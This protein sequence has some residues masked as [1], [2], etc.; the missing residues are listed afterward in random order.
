MLLL[1]FEPRPYVL[2]AERQAARLKPEHKPL[3][4][5]IVSMSSRDSILWNRLITAEIEAMTSATPNEIAAHRTKRDFDAM[6]KQIDRIE[7]VPRR[8]GEPYTAASRDEI[9]DVLYRLE[10]LSQKEIW[11]AI[12]IRSVLSL[13]EP[14][15]SR[16]Q[17]TGASGSPISEAESANTTADIAPPKASSSIADA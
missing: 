1:D 9:M 13:G 3:T 4:F 15:R 14:P 12:K 6:A 8:D 16:S 2:E 5:W 17:S 11:L 7:N 10:E